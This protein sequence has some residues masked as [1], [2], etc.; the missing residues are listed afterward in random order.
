MQLREGV[1]DVQPGTDRAFGLGLMR[2]GKAEEGDD[3]IA[4]YPEDISF[5]A[6]DAGL[7][8]FLVAAK[9]DLHG[10]GIELVRELGEAHHV[11]EQHRQMAPFARRRITLMGSPRLLCRFLPTHQIEDSLA[12]YER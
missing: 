3:A 12:R 2:Q 9:H 7:A 11:A 6:I 10:F 4:E 5:V 1:D 8:G